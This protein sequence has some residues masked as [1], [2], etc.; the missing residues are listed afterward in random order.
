MK[1]GTPKPVTKALLLAG[2]L[3][4]R[5]RPLTDRMP[6]CLVPIGGRTLLDYW[7]DALERAGVHEV[8]VNNHHLPEVLRAHV[9]QINQRGAIRMREAFEPVLLGSAG[10]I[11][12]NRSWVD[13]ADAC[14]IVYADNLSRVDLPAVL[15]AHR[16]QEHPVTMMLFHTPYP[17]RC[18]IAELDRAGTV[19]GFVEKPQH[20][21]SDLAN[22]GLYVMSADAFREVADMKAFDL[23]FDVLPRFIGRM[24]GWVWDG[25]HRDIGTLESLQAAEREAPLVF[26][27]SV[28][29]GVR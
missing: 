25:Y 8:L 9:D 21:T 24:H 17:S 1:R 26:G 19:V 14:L 11:H 13:D 18:G 23:A 22:A 6:K 12:A 20:P 27:E 3:G 5:L 10:T 7:C 15:E 16:A 2:G 4:T 29:G 28:L